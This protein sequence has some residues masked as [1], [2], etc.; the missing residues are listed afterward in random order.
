MEEWVNKYKAA[1]DLINDK[2]EV[3][4]LN[5]D[6]IRDPYC[7][8]FNLYVRMRIAGLEKIATFSLDSQYIKSIITDLKY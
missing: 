7:L 6:I 8:S 2:A 1:F 5:T 3:E 4:I